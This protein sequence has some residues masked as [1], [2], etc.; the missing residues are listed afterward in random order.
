MRALAGHQGGR[1]WPKT[2]VRGYAT[3]SRRAR[4]RRPP[5]ALV[6]GDWPAYQDL[7]GVRHNAITLGSMAAH[8][9]LSWIHR[10]FSNLKCWGVG[11]YHGLRKPNLQHYLDEFVSRFK[12]A[13][14]TACR[15][16]YSAPPSAPHHAKL[17]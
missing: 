1:G 14:D 5:E 15:L 12:S 8:I 4:R 7:P 2:A 10:L 11:V 3:H 17:P 13:P 9:A 6:T 16:R